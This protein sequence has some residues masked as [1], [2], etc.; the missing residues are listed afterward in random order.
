MQVQHFSYTLLFRKFTFEKNA[1]VLKMR[2][3]LTKPQNGHQKQ[4]CHHAIR[5]TN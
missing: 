4:K 1:F 2:F 5:L 3:Y